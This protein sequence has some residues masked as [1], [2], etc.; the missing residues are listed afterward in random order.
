VVGALKPECAYSTVE[1]NPETGLGS[2]THRRRG[3]DHALF[4]LGALVFKFEPNKHRNEPL[5]HVKSCLEARAIVFP[6]SSLQQ[7]LNDRKV[8]A[9]APVLHL[10]ICCGHESG[11]VG[12]AP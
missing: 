7:V 12:I 2:P 3:L 8:R 6:C 1:P 11:F 10:Y 4:L 9:A 5:F